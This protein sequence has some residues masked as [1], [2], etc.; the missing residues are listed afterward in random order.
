MRGRGA[1]LLTAV[2]LAAALGLFRERER[3]IAGAVGFNGFPLDDAWI[4][5]QFARNLASGHGF[6]YNPDVPVAGSTAPLWTLLLAGLF[7]LGGAHPAWSKLAGIAAA[8]AAACL[9]RWLALLWTGDRAL[10]LTAA[11]ATAWSAP[12]VWGALSGMEVA[13]AA[14]LVTGALVAHAAGRT[15]LSAALV[16]LAALTRPEAVLLVPLLWLGGPLTVSRTAVAWGV[17]I[18]M[19]APW[20]AFNLRTAGTPLPA[21]A[22]AKIDGGLVGLLAGTR[23]PLATTLLS[24]PW[25]FDREWIAWLGSIN[26]LLPVLLLPGLWVVWRRGG[27]FWAWPASILLFHPIGMALLAPYRGPAFQEGRYSI[28]LLPL[29]MVV[30]VSALAPL[31]WAVRVQA[32]WARLACAILLAASLV[33]LGAGATRYAWAVQNIDAMQ[34]AL[35][36]WVAAETPPD[37]RLALNDVGAITYLGGRDVIDV[38]GLVTPAIIPYRREGEAGVLR[39]LTEACPDYLIVFPAWFPGLSARRDLF[40]PVHRVKLAHNTVAGADEMVVYETVWNRRRPAPTPCP[41]GTGSG[42]GR[43]Q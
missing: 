40:T 28:H 34:V 19:L 3:Q 25:Q 32:V 6:S 33:P 10:G 5:F 17:P 16:G 24:R 14:A 4:H 36:R 9:A 23:E 42:A 38:M 7:K 11:L 26:L 37:A 43:P 2:A 13:V 15:A 12:L 22:A 18:A 20:V 21:T 35:G 30:A 39:Y 1:L 29:A 27:R 8:L 31:A 41:A